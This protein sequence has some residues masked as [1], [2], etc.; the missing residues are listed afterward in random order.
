MFALGMVGI[1][2]SFAVEEMTD[3]EMMEAPLE[4]E[5]AFETN[6][7]YIN[8]IEILGANIIKPEF[9]LKKM[10]LQKG[11]LYDKD[12]M[13]QDLKTIYK[14]GYFT[15]RMKAIPVKNSNGTISLKII[16]EEN[17]PVTDFTIEG[18]T[19]VSSD[20]L[21]R[22]LLPLKGK[23]QN[24]TDI[25]AAMEKIN[26]C[27]YSKGYILSKIDSIYDDP[28]GTLNLSIT[29]GK[30]NKI[31]ISGNEKTKEY[32]VERNIMTEPDTVYNE[33]IIKQ[34]LVRLYS[35]QA[36][37]DV[38]RTIEVSQ[39]NPDK[40]DITIEL[41]EQRTA[42]ISLGGGLDS[43]TG[44]FGSVGISDNNF[45][46]MNQRVSLTGLVGSGI[47]MSDSSIKSHMN[48]QAELSF[49]EPHFL[50]ADN[51]LMSKIYYRDL[52]SYQIPLAIER[53]IGIEST[54][55]HRMRINP[56]LSTTFTTGIEHIHLSE[57]DANN[58]TN[59]YNKYG[60]NIA[61]RAKQ[62]EG[63][64]FLRLAPGIAYD[65]RDSAVNPRNGS[66]VSARFEEAFGLD[67]FGKTNGRL[68]GM[69]K[70]YV[71]VGKKSS[72][73]FTGRGGLKVHGDN[74]PEIMAYRLGGPYTVRGYK[75]NG[76]GTGTSFIMGSAEL[77]T[78]L[79]FVDRFKVNFLHNLRMTF[80]VDAGKVFNPTIS[81]TLYERPIHAIT[82][83]VGLK[84]TI[85]GVGPLS[86]DY[87]FPLTNPGP[88]GSRNGY[89]TFGAGDM[90][91]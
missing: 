60:L 72:L 27:Y 31:L 81:S 23:P 62:L 2:A 32:V 9:I 40:F 83:G 12:L 48:Y 44:A 90:M 21:M 73:T 35:T 28:D 54:V 59:L 68:L 77:A 47:L 88:N 43:A 85:P 51:S 78:P 11:D 71:P 86:I 82:A 19:V 53:R 39:D 3:K 57:G 89:F 8:D 38:N 22:Y 58:I 63:G 30:I 5:H 4:E 42:A 61:D 13:Q 17:V 55:A 15:E 84:I 36:F 87:G 46:G 33:N 74:M 45:R 65:S 76:V 79:P 70:R 34:D 1:P 20:E 56:H 52:G 75:V 91:Y 18:N 29:E 80:W 69:A 66:L 41:K 37:K 64:L 6:T 49:F 26:A 67:G 50:N 10:S 24:I 7:A 14:L 25:N 16:L